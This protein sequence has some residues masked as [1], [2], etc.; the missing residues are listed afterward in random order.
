M[1]SIF[2]SALERS[3]AEERAA[4]LEAACGTDVESRARIEA[5]LQAHEEAGGFLPEQSGNR[6]PRATTDQSATEYPG[7]MVGPYKLLEQIGEGGFGVVFMAEQ[8]QPVRRKVALKVLKPG[9][10]SK[11]VIARF[12]AERQALALMDHLNIAKVLDGGETGTGRPYFVMDLVKGVPITHYGDQNQLTARERLELFVQVCQAVQHAHQKAIIHRDVKPSNVLVS[13]HDDTPVV[14]VI[15]FGIAKAVGQQLTDKTL[16][17]NFAQLVGTPLYMSPEQAGMSAL[18]V[19]TRSD[20]YSLGVLL[21]ELLT[22]TTPF[23]SQR[24][25][26]VGFDELRRIIREEEP[27]RPSTRISTLGQ[28]AT[29]VST[30]RKSD[31]K[32]LSRLFRGEL[33]WM[34]MKALEKDRNR[35]Y[36]SASAFAADVQRYLHDE[37]VLACPP[38][39][40]YRLG[41]LVRRNKGKLA[42]AACVS[43]AVMVMAASIGWA[44]GDRAARLA[45]VAGQVGESLQTVNTLIAENKLAAARQK[46]A[47]ARAQLGSHR[48]ALGELAAVVE[49]GENEMELFQQFLE[50]IDRAHQA[51]TAPRL[52][53]TLAVDASQGA[54]ATQLKRDSW[55]RQPAAAVP[56][57]L[58]ALDL[59]Q[60]L[61]RDDWTI[62]LGG[63]LLG[64]H[65]SEQIRR[66]AYEELLWLGDD[67][68]HRRQEHRS[69]AQLS[70]QAAARQAL[71]YMD[72][73]AIA[74][75]PTQAFYVLRA[76]CR[77]ALGE[78]VAAQADWQLAKQT[79]PTTALDHCLRGQA[80]FEAK[81]RT[82]ALQAFEAALRQE[83][84]HYWSLLRLGCAWCEFGQSPQELRTASAVFSGC[85]LKRPEHAHAYYCRSV[86]F[87]RLHDYKQA[88]VD[89]SR[90][91]DLALQTSFAWSNRGVYYSELD[92]WDRAASDFTR[93][94]E[95]NPTDANAWNNRG[96]AHARLGQKDKA[97]GDFTRAIE[98]KP[99]FVQALANRGNA[100]LHQG[101][102]GKAVADCSRCIELNP[103][104]FSAWGNRGAAYL[105]LGQPDKAVAD[106]SQAIALK[107]EYAIAWNNRGL[108][109]GALAKP[110][111]ALADFSQAIEHDPK[112]V[113]AW[114]N[115]GNAC[116]KMAQPVKAVADYTRAIELNPK[117]DRA[118]SMRG[119]A[120]CDRLGRPEKAIADFS[121]AIAL[122][123]TN[124]RYWGNR[125]NA[126]LNAGQPDKAVADYNR[127]IALYAR[128]APV[129]YSRGLAHRQLGQPVKAI[130]D[131]SEAIRL[132]PKYVTAWYNRGHAYLLLGQAD[133]AVADFSEAIALNPTLA[134]YWYVRGDAYRQLGRFREALSDYQRARK[135]APA[136]A[137]THD[138]LARLL[139]ICPEPRLRDPA[140]AVQLARRALQL[141]PRDGNC[142]NT[143]GLAQYG[144][145]DYASAIAALETSAKLGQGGNAVDFFFLALS[146]HKLAHYEDAIKWYNKGLAWL[147]KNK[148]SLERDK[149]GA[150]ELRRFRSE[151]ETGL[152]LKKK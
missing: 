111:K 144:A 3:N 107:P 100:Y 124:S 62:I 132:N 12:E 115:R 54:P 60:I 10:D 151:A 75:R 21:Y 26:E 4:Y 6:D 43:L 1:L 61:E 99:K 83:P 85:I 16:F 39:V 133:K 138:A 70:P 86:V 65:Q 122:N 23:D 142:W 48:S 146:H 145:G 87:F 44:V 116:L 109:H 80:A 14:K 45:S 91:I 89:C 81:Q 8:Q 119:V 137:R 125:G 28:A 72:K 25:K 18:D 141:A 128:Y 46:L 15:D 104:L 90:A 47:E 68:F 11:Q 51:E 84:T 49:A 37:A 147:E 30:S 105:D 106:F 76:R 97:L 129:W 58:R 73:A 88:V 13:R 31:P 110:D 127:S 140:R 42:V 148:E 57:L 120:Y 24:L 94:I 19:D 67:V 32:Q 79:P 82:E 9:M 50:L 117:Y 96:A 143:L 69:A 53:A 93:A 35:R 114:Y 130:A 108:A 40:R 22:G 152:D 123:A 36:E 34:V 95:L 17:T 7:T 59:Y 77:K 71:V 112:L 149:S 41:K 126:H 98:L 27:P 64:R 74:H 66:L 78:E 118:W 55:E 113:E 102:P 56:F 135:R 52:D 136:E 121:Q 131:F 29:T 134:G 150:E 92:Q 101:E 5:L 38:S 33:D 2:C 63:G 20:I 103:K 139:A